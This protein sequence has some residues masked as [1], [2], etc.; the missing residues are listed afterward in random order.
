MRIALFET[1]E[2]EPDYLRRVLRHHKLTF[3]PGPLSARTIG[4][5]KGADAISVFIHS[6]VNTPALAALPKLKLVTTRSTGFDHIDLAAC[7]KRGITVCNVP[8]YGENT[9]AEHAFALLLAIA[10]RIPQAQQKTSRRDFSIDGLQGFDL[11]GK[12]LGV[13]GGGHIGIHAVS[14]GN[15][16]GMQVLVFDIHPDPALAKKYKF[17][18]ASFSALLRRS[19]VITIH[20]PYNPLTHHLINRKNIGLIKKG[21]VLIN[22]ARGGIV[23]TAALLSALDKNIAAAGLDVV[24]GEELILKKS[25]SQNEQRLM[26]LTTKLLRKKNVL[27]TPHIA[28]YTQEALQRIT[29]TTVE[30]IKA[31]AIGKPRNVVNLKK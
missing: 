27:F 6:T 4:A 5:A 7:A 24:E 1:K 20:A 21:A 22:T 10:R 30:S 19:D 12:T 17:V 23:D 28:F 3:S 26:D 13:I 9:V 2:W 25:L 8:F 14:I 29:D 15:G 31:F 16:F 11:A 18:Y